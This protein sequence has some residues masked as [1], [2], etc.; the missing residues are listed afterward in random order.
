MR[1]SGKQLSEERREEEMEL[2]KLIQMP[3]KMKTSWEN[4]R[5]P[6]VMMTKKE[7]LQQ[8]ACPPREERE[9]KGQIQELLKKRS[10]VMELWTRSMQLFLQFQDRIMNS[11]GIVM[12]MKLSKTISAIKCRKIDKLL[13]P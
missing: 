6:T 2:K 4:H 7:E 9:K 5:T 1:F 12:E 8:I 10:E 11:K 13:R 3:L